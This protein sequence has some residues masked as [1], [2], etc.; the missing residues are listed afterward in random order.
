MS[1]LLALNFPTFK[2]NQLFLL[3]KPVNPE[4]DRRHGSNLVSYLRLYSLTMNEVFIVIMNWTWT[5]MLIFVD[6]SKGHAYQT[7]A[8]S[9]GEY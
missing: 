9:L 6:S 5:T 3:V 7:Y 1:I 8:G 4:I 2:R